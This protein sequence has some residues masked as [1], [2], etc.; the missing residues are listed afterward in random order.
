MMK[1]IFEV[2]TKHTAETIKQYIRF[3]NNVVTP[4][5][6]LQTLLICLCF[7]ALFFLVPVFYVKIAIIVLVFI[8][9]FR[10]STEGLFL[11][12]YM[13]RNDENYIHQNW[14]YYHFFED[15]F[16]LESGLSKEK[17]K[18]TYSDIDSYYTDENYYYFWMQNGQLHLF[19]KK[20]LLKGDKKN[21]VTFI[22]KKTGKQMQFANGS[23]QN[24]VQIMQGRKENADA[25][26]RQKRK[27][28]W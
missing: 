2:K 5:K 19:R 16:E 25:I 7:V 23:M 4:T 11:S 9:V 26:K 6:R 20:E 27:W 10:T 17:T 14:L 15:Y 22:R 28:K 13:K 1:P 24:K 21:F 8:L 3:Q 12:R 18:I